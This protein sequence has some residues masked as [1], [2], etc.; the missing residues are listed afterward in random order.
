MTLDEMKRWF[1]LTL[2]V[3]TNLTID[4][5]VIYSADSDYG[6]EIF[7]NFLVF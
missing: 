7:L 4:K 1:K 2:D 3:L 6:L 5:C